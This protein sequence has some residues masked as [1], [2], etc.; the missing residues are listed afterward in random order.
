RSNLPYNPPKDFAMVHGIFTVPWIIVA[1]PS[2]PYSTIKEMVSYSKKHP[3]KLTWGYGACSLQLGAEL[4]K[5][6]TGA[7]L[8]GVAYKGTAPANTDV[9]GGHIPLSIS[10]VAA[11]LPHIKSDKMKPLATLGLKRMPLLPDVPTDHEAG[12]KGFE[13]E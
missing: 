11:T 3:G 9:L 4:F 13:A 12:Y 7:Q 2:T 6:T 5:F 10:T 8:V 1:H